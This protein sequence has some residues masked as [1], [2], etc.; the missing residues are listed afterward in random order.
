MKSFFIQVLTCVCLLPLAAACRQQQITI[1]DVKLDITVSD[2]TVGETTLLLSVRDKD[3][4][5]IDNPG[6][7]IVRG[8]MNH[9]GMAPVFAQSNQSVAGVFTLSFQWTMAGAWTLE[10]TLELESGDVVKETFGLE[11]M[12]E[13]T[14][15]APSA[16]HSTM[17]GETSAVYMRI[18]NAGGSTVIIRSAHTTAAQ[19]VE[20]HQTIVENDI[21]RMQAIDALV[22]PVGE[23]L[24]LRPGGV[25]I[26]LRQLT[27]D[28]KPGTSV[29]LRLEANKGDTIQLT[30][31][32]MQM[33]I[34]SSESSAKAGDLEI[35]NLWARP[36]N[37]G[38]M[39]DMD[40]R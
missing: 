5:V 22:I 33:M 32:I 2:L 27:G 8:D 10:A 40:S 36:A 25:H 28:L 21:A 24:E 38:G 29:E 1:G 19:V 12:F 23:T 13:A 11:V 26:M 3:D 16:E 35:S 39:M 4:K 20:F 37:A 18:K 17:V 15:D 31:P 34:D 14:A 30:V 6:S 9:A 7:I